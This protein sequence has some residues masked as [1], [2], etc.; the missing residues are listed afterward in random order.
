MDRA[1]AVVAH[2]GA[3]DALAAWWAV[4]D[5]WRDWLSTEVAESTAEEYESALL[6]F[7]RRSRTTPDRLTEEQVTG[8]LR[9]INPKGPAAQLCLR[10]LKSY[11]R[12]ACRRGVHHDNPVAELRYRS[13]KYPPV[14]VLTQQ[15]YASIV[16]AAGRHGERRAWTLVLLLETGAR[17]GSLAG[18]TVADVGTQPGDL[19]R[20][21]TAKGDRPYAVPLSILAAEAVRG[22]LADTA[23]RIHPTLIGV[24]KVTIWR[25][26]HDAAIEAGLPPGKRHSHLARHTAATDL[27]R[28][29]KDPLLVKKF[30]NHADLSTIHRYADVTQDELAA[31]L[32]PG[33]FRGSG[34]DATIRPGGDG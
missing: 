26:F 10:S 11:Y 33:F 6:R 20:F 21:R 2:S 24:H 17:I 8:Y 9:S 29:T 15:E 32:R 3:F 27:Y 19:I 18:V 16:A 1:L 13:P 31:E 34:E 14:V 12:W 22:L 4:L 5:Q 30:L 7:F 28:R 25:W 23:P